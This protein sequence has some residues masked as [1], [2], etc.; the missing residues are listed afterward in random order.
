MLYEVNNTFGERHKYV[1][2]VE[3]D[4]ATA[5]EQDCDKTFHVSPFMAMDV[6][7]AFRVNPPGQRISIAIQGR[8]A[9]GPIIN[10]VLAG[11]RKALSDAR[12]L[13]AFF[14]IPLLTVKV[15]LAIHWE[16][17]RMWLKG[18][19]VFPHPADRADGVCPEAKD[20]TA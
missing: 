6:I 12:L 5:I 19:R 3:Q 17:L 14:S 8:D 2:P 18:F 1:L 4:A 11:E 20:P 9:D 13:Q 16:A 15:T 10:T 7:Y